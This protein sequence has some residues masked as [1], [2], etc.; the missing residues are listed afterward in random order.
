MTEL[1]DT[2]R[3]RA[4]AFQALIEGTPPERWS[5]PSPCQGWLA[6][7]VVAHVVD[8][9]AR[10]VRERAGMSDVPVFAGFGHPAAAFGATRQ[11]LE[12]LLDDEA[13]PP[14]VATHLHWSLSFDLPQH[15][16][17]LAVATGQDPTM[18]PEEV[19]LLWGSLN[20][21]K[22]QWD[23]QRANGWYGTPVPVPEDAPL[24]DRVIG[25]LGRNPTWR[26]TD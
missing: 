1:G 5:S 22:D 14:K 17:D 9:S 10:V 8:Y 15:G 4:D 16:W 2:Y 23:W 20:G 7:D 12:R 26:P 13:T 21:A 18:D 24:Q 11:M 6:R 3:R 19:E 25:L